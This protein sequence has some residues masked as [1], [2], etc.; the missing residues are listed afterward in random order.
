M[1]SSNV[2]ENN[3]NEQ[4]NDNVMWLDDRSKYE[5]RDRAREGTSGGSLVSLAECQ[6][7]R[8]EEKQARRYARKNIKLEHQKWENNY[9]W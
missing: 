2:T 3:E 4:I 7:F 8:R 1:W 9:E 5:R 6:K